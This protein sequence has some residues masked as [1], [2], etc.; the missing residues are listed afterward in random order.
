MGV[1]A[2]V[3]ARELGV[4]TRTLAVWADHGKI[5]AT[6]TASGWRMYDLA[7]IARVKRELA[8]RAA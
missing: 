6:K 4:S 2:S 7:D 8:R 5:K 1:F 3:A